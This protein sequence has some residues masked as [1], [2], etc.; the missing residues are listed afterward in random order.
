MIRI[1]YYIAYIQITMYAHNKHIGMWFTS[2]AFDTKIDSYFPVFASA[3]YGAFAT[4][5]HTYLNVVCHGAEIRRKLLRLLA[6]DKSRV[7][8]HFSRQK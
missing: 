1:Y 4:R 6:N 2:A 7:C 8:K 3:Y 5:I